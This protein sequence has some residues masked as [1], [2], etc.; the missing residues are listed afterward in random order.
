M[1]EKQPVELQAGES[2][3]IRCR[4][5]PV[6]LAWQLS[7]D[8]LAGVVPIVLVLLLAHYTSGL[9]STFGQIALVLS[10]VWGVFWL[11]RGYLTWYR[12]QN[13]QWLITNQ[14]LIDSIRRHWFHHQIASADLIHVEDMTVHK[15]GVLPTMFGFGDVR[16]QTAGQAQNFVL[17]GIPD[18]ERVLATIDAA[19]DASRRELAGG[20]GFAATTP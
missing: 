17:S 8:V 12:Y 11:I 13:D 2:I 7:R 20:P 3:I 15:N 19:R 5:H 16:C 4:R 9:D 1:A 14:R 6:F 10:I 18:P